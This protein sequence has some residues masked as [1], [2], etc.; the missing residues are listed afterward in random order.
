MMKDTHTRR[1]EWEDEFIHASVIPY[2]YIVLRY[3]LRVR[4]MTY[5]DTSDI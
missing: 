4:G 3:D 1:Y 2:M 5:Y